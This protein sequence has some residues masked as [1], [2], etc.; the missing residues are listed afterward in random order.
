MCTES[1]LESEISRF[2]ESFFRNPYNTPKV[3]EYYMY[4]ANAASLRS[5]DLSRQ[6]GA[7]L[8][9]QERSLLTKG[10]NEVPTFGGNSYWP[11]DPPA[12]DN[13][14]WKKGNDF[15][16]VKKVEILEELMRFLSEKSLVSL[17]DKSTPDSVVDRLVFGDEKDSFRNLRVSNLIE[18]GRMVHAEMSALMEAARRG[19]SVQGASL[20]CTTFPCHM[21]ARHIISAGVSKVVYIEPYPKSMTQELFPE[22]VIID[23]TLERN[24]G[25]D[26]VAKLRFEPFVGVATRIYAQL[27]SYI[28]RKDERG[29]TVDWSKKD[30]QP[31]LC[32][33]ATG[34]LGLEQTLAKDVDTIE[35]VGLDDLDAI[36]GTRSW[37]R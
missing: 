11:D 25:A 7:V 8:V 26:T 32:S 13:R 18:F 17:D 33:L 16:A 15:N 34:H 23:S 35:Q 30:A 19:I 1:E 22:T 14:D 37:A 29:Y 10:C 21:C 9:T 24:A 28:R 5:A 12:L 6:I 3:D 20:Y 4:E 2:F 31:R 36:E 27:Y